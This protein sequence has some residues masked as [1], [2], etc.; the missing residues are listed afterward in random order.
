MIEV[1]FVFVIMMVNIDVSIINW[2]G[3]K[4]IGDQYIGMINILEGKLMVEGFDFVG[5]IFVIDMNIIKNIDLLE[6]K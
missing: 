4:F 3:V 5:G 6:D 1:V 2:V